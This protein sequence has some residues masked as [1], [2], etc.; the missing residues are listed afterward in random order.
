MPTAPRLDSRRDSAMHRPKLSLPD[1]DG[2]RLEQLADALDRDHQV[3][4]AQHISG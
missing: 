1:S 3:R 2:G 4:L